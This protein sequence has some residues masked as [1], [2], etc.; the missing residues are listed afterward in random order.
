[1]HPLYVEQKKKLSHHQTFLVNMN[2]LAE[3]GIVNYFIFQ[4]TLADSNV[5]LFWAKHS[6]V[7]HNCLL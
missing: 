2:N 4:C 6:Y 5:V 7:D 3:C 1:M